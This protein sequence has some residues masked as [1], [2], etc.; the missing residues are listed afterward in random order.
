VR[1]KEPE[2]SVWVAARYRP[3]E[4]HAPHALVPVVMVGRVAAST[5][6]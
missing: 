2:E 6:T 3:M 1:E 4:G 5:G